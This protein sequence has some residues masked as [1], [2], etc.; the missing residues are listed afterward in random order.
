[1][2]NKNQAIIEVP[3]TASRIGKNT[4]YEG[5][6]KF[7][8][9]MS[10]IGKVKGSIVGGEL[11]II[12]PNAIVEGDIIA[13]YLLI[14]GSVSGNINARKGVYFF[15]NSVVRGTVTSAVIRM[16]TGV[17]FDGKCNLNIEEDVDI[18]SLSRQSFHISMFD[19]LLHELDEIY[20]S[21]HKD[22]DRK[23]NRTT[24]KMEVQE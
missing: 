3:Q 15:E 6:L 4:M 12:H 13:D 19:K 24:E 17:D 2:A 7:K 8:T 16:Q 1:M 5:V 10:V 22:S 14:I 11:L 21:H 20:F 23:D 18:F 9:S